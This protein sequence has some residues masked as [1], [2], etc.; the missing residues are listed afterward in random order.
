MITLFGAFHL[1]QAAPLTFMLTVTTADT[2]GRCLYQG[3]WLEVSG[4]YHAWDLKEIFP[5]KGSKPSKDDAWRVVRTHHWN[6]LRP[7]APSPSTTSSTGAISSDIS[8]AIPLLNVS[9]EQLRHLETLRGEDGYKF[10]RSKRSSLA[11][12]DLVLATVTTVI[13]ESNLA[14]LNRHN[15]S[16]PFEDNSTN[17]AQIIIPLGYTVCEL[18]PNYLMEQSTAIYTKGFLGRK[19]MLEDNTKPMQNGRKTFAQEFIER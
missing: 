5:K 1:V 7:V 17:D 14:R 13:P 16:S 11:N 2:T 18:M 9:E 15:M 6:Q 8:F 3:E 12:E 19:T 4:R 10:L